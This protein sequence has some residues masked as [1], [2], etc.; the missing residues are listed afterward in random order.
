M[1]ARLSAI[2]GDQSERIAWAVATQVN[3]NHIYVI[4]H[5]F[6]CGMPP[7]LTI[8]LIRNFVRR[9]SQLQ[10]TLAVQFE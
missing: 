3:G 7:L 8:R 2:D 4:S 6:Q 5:A 10:A 9:K 1:S